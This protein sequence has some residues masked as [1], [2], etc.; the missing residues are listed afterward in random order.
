MLG[1]SI[2]RVSPQRLQTTDTDGDGLSDYAEFIG[3]ESNQRDLV[4][5]IVNL[6]NNQAD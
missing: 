1:A 5:D 3:L 4:C 2:F 6:T